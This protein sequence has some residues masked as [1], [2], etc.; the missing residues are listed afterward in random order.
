MLTIYR[1]FPLLVQ[2]L[3]PC[4]NDIWVFYFNT[5]T[6]LRTFWAHLSAKQTTAFLLFLSVGVFHFH[7]FFTLLT[8]RTPFCFRWTLIVVRGAVSWFKCSLQTTSLHTLPKCLT[9]FRSFCLSECAS[10]WEKTSVF[11]RLTHNI[12]NFKNTC[13]SLGL[14]HQICQFND[15]R[16]SPPF[17]KHDF[18]GSSVKHLSNVFDSDFDYKNFFGCDEA[19][20]SKHAVIRGTRYSTNDVLISSV[21][22]DSMPMFELVMFIVVNR[23]QVYFIRER[24]VV[25]NFDSSSRSYTISKQ[26]LPGKTV[27]PYLDLFVFHPL[28]RH[29]CFVPGCSLCIF[30]CVINCVSITLQKCLTQWCL[31]KTLNTCYVFLSDFFV[32][33][34]SFQK[35]ISFFFWFFSC[36]CFFYSF[37]MDFWN[38]SALAFL[39]LFNDFLFLLRN[40]P[41][42]QI[43][44]HENRRNYFGLQYTSCA[45]SWQWNGANPEN[46]FHWWLKYARLFQKLQSLLNFETVRAS[47]W[48]SCKRRC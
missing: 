9:R 29:S 32:L 39:I 41:G 17:K 31:S 43:W 47:F 6:W 36:A 1:F 37:G 15:W 19:L 48:V 27:V 44:Y 7:D 24:I 42:L 18:P 21:S 33:F 40:G 10:L 30:V 38:S 13:K 5:S 16:Q 8:L 3:V 11:L 26:N 28:S 34:R 4:G 22:S 2:E 35:K 45:T 23:S 25:K 14:Q 20:V 12:C 46:L